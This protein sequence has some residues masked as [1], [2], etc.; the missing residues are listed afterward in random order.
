MNFPFDPKNMCKILT[1]E[2]NNQTYG[3]SSCPAGQ[4]YRCPFEKDNGYAACVDIT[5]KDWREF[6]EKDGKHGMDK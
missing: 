5:W 1:H 4:P 3:R 6:F 2:C